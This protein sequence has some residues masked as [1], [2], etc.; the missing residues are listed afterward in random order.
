MLSGQD[1]YTNQVQ[2]KLN[3][4]A[5]QIADLALIIEIRRKNRRGWDMELKEN[6]IQQHSALVST[7]V[8]MELPGTT[9]FQTGIHFVV[10]VTR[11]DVQVQ[12]SGQLDVGE[13]Q[14]SGQNLELL[15]LHRTIVKRTKIGGDAS[16]KIWL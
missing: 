3:K 16:P 6:V 8:D 15:S 10:V 9:R 14:I 7:N 11:M 5:H 13:D 1:E 12:I 4:L 2:D